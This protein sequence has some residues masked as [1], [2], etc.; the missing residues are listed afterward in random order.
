MRVADFNGELV[1]L[2]EVAKGAADRS[3]GIQV[4]RLAGLPEAVV[5][6]AQ[7]ILAELEAGERKRPVAQIEDLPLFSLAAPPVARRDDVREALQ[8][9][10]P[11]ELSPRAALEALYQLR[12]LA[13]DKT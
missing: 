4:A 5:K 10:N 12:R 6:R 3:Y 2:H 7:I 11:D 1:F 9:L 13:G 8:A